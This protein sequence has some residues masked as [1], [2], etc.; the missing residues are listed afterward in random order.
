ML[1]NLQE[2][3]NKVSNVPDE[4][5]RGQGQALYFCGKA[6]AYNYHSQDQSGNAFAI[7]SGIAAI[8]AATL[9]A[10]NYRPSWFGLAKNVSTS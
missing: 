4:N 6:F 3:E 8:V 2:C 5:S 7:T 9:F 10:T 1:R